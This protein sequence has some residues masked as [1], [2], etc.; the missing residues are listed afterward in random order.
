[1]VS[2][3][4]VEDKKEKQDQSIHHAALHLANVNDQVKAKL[5]GKQND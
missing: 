2:V 1:M 5:G 3:N 4:H